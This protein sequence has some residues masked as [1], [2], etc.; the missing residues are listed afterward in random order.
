[1]TEFEQVSLGFSPLQTPEK[2][3]K[4]LFVFLVN[5]TQFFRLS[6]LSQ[7]PLPSHKQNVIYDIDLQPLDTNNYC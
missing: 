2:I 4:W 1:M 7:K 3:A 6:F 5:I